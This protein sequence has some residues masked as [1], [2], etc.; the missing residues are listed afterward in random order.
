MRF[1]FSAMKRLRLRAAWVLLPAYLFFSRPSAPLIL[2][3]VGLALTGGLLRAWAAGTIRKNVILT[4]GGPYAHTRN[5]LYLGTFLIG[6]GLAV[7]S[8]RVA[9][10]VGF[11]LFFLAVYGWTMRAESRRLERLF[12]DDYRHYAE[13]VPS[14]LP[15]LRPY[16]AS[17]AP[18]TRFDLKSLLV[19][20]EYQAV[21][22][23]LLAFLALA[24]KLAL[25]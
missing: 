18:R 16:R 20:R 23:T 24:A 13:S 15:R 2:T 22:G 21:L 12:G 8:G 3:G 25:S 4:T 10:I 11:L 6:L 7:A 5:P 1:S 17:A 9:I 19:S 14:F